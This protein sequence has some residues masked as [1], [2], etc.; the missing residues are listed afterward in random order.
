MLPRTAAA[1]LLNLIHQGIKLIT[2]FI[3]AGRYAG[4]PTVQL[5]RSGDQQHDPGPNSS[6]AHPTGERLLQTLTCTVIQ[7]WKTIWLDDTFNR[8]EEHLTSI[9][10]DT[11]KWTAQEF[12]RLGL[13]SKPKVAVFDC[14][15]T[16][17]DGDSGGG[18]LKWS[19]DQG[20]VSRSTRDW[21]DTR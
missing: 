17:W 4:L 18:L 1:R 20:L 10:T 16:L 13:E 15:G 5:R 8:T 9:Q 19:I 14:D 7:V 12:Q 3:F 11:K 21:V 6:F 2:A